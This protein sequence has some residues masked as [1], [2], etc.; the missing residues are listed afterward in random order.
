M[1]TE[2]L[3]GPSLAEFLFLFLKVLTSPFVSD[4]CQANDDRPGETGCILT[5]KANQYVSTHILT[6]V[7]TL[8]LLP[9][10]AIVCRHP[11]VCTI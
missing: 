3:S 2:V 10:G 5:G 1:L 6:A 4:D 9:T 8:N 11:S 7:F